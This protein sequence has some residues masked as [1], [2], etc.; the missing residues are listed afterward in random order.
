MI[1]TCIACTVLL[2]STLDRTV[3]TF[4]AATCRLVKGPTKRRIGRSDLSPGQAFPDGRFRTFFDQ[5]HTQ[6]IVFGRLF[7]P[8]G[9]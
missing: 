5:S 6:N 2:Y 1:S 3:R 8:S 7:M 4:L 9:I